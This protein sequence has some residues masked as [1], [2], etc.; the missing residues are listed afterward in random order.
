MA[1]L[2]ADP[3]G[4]EGISVLL[5]ISSSI[6]G[7]CDATLEG[8]LLAAA[9]ALA[10]AAVSALSRLQ[11]RKLLMASAEE[12]GRKLPKT[13]ERK[14]ENTNENTIDPGGCQQI[15]HHMPTMPTMPT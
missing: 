13:Q 15:L 11:K 5:G 2:L 14:P 12:L 10:I 1:L 7:P 4:W 3:A 6:K 8:L 9:S